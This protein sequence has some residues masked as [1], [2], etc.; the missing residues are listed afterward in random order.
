[1]VVLCVPNLVSPSN[2][3][4]F[5]SKM[6]KMCYISI[7]IVLSNFS[8]SDFGLAQLTRYADHLF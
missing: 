5:A 2:Y 7:D 1:M 8:L 3:L 4:L 6:I